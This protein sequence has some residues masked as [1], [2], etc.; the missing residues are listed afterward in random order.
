[1]KGDDDGRGEKVRLRLRRR[2]LF[3]SRYRDD[4][5]TTATS[6]EESSIR[7]TGRL[8]LQE[9]FGRR[10]TTMEA[11]FGP[12]PRRFSAKRYAPEKGEMVSDGQDRNKA[13]ELVA[14]HQE[15]RIQN[16]RLSA[17]GLEWK[18]IAGL[19]EPAARAGL[20]E[21][22]QSV[23]KN[24]GGIIDEAEGI[25]CAPA[26]ALGGEKKVRAQECVA[27]LRWG[28][29]D[30]VR[31]EELVRELSSSIDLLYDLSKT[32]KEMRRGTYPTGNG[33]SGPPPAGRYLDA[34]ASS[35]YN[36]SEET[37]V[38]PSR[39]NTS[40]TAVSLE[41]PPR[42]ELSNLDLPE[43]EPPAYVAENAQQPP[44]RVIGHL[45]Q[46]AKSWG[47][48]MADSWTVPV[49]VEY[50][51]FDPGYRKTGI[52][53][54]T[55]RLESLLSFYARCAPLPDF[56]AFATLPCLGFFEDPKHSRYGLV[57]ELPK[58]VQAVPYDERIEQRPA[59]LLQALQ[60]TMPQGS[61]SRVK[62][63]SPALEERFRLALNVV[64][65]FA[66]LHHEEQVHKD[67]NSTNIV[68]FNTRP[69]GGGG[70]ADAKTKYNL[71]APYVAS[72]DVFSEYSIEPLSAAPAQNLYR[73]PEDRRIYEAA[74]R[75]C[76]SRACK[77]PKYRF[78][79]YGLAVVLLEIGL[80]QPV[81][82]LYK[83]PYSLTEFKHRRLQNVYVR[84]LASRCG[85]VFMNVVLD[86]LDTSDTNVVGEVLADKY[87]RWL[88][89]LRRCCMLD[90]DEDLDVRSMIPSLGRTSPFTQLHSI[91]P[92]PA[93]AAPVL[94]ETHPFR[95]LSHRTSLP[96]SINEANEE[97]G[98][99]LEKTRDS[100]R[101]VDRKPSIATLRPRADADNSSTFSVSSS[102][103][104][105]ASV[106]ARAWRTKVC[107][108]T[109]R[110]CRAKVITLQ[111]CWRKR[112]SRTTSVATSQT[113]D[114]NASEAAA[115]DMPSL[116]ASFMQAEYMSTTTMTSDATH[117]LTHHNIA[118]HALITIA[119]PPRPRPKLRVFPIKLAKDALDT[120]HTTTLPRLERLLDRALRDSPETVSIDLLGVGDAPHSTR[121]T[122]FV[123]CDSVPRVRAVLARRFAA[124]PGFDL[125]IRRGCIRRSKVTRPKRCP[126]HRSMAPAADAPPLNPFHQQRPLCGASIGAW[127]GDRHLPPVSYGGV[128][129]VDGRAYGMT[130]HH[131]L[132]APSDDESDAG[133]EESY[134]SG[135]VQ[136]SA[137]RRPDNSWFAGLAGHPSLQALPPDGM[138]A[139][140]ISDDELEDATEEDWDGDF[141]Y[142]SYSDSESD[143]EE[144]G[145][146]ESTHTEGDAPG[147]V[148]HSHPPI[149]VT[150]PALDDVV[151]DFFPAAE[152]VDDDHLSSHTLGTV[153][154][155]SGIRRAQLG[156]VVH[157]IDWALLALAPERLQ[158]VNL[159][160]GGR[161]FHPAACGAGKG[162]GAAVQ[163]PVCRGAGFAAEED[164][165]PVRIAGADELG[166]LAVHCFGRTS[167]L[168]GGV[169]GE[170]M[171]SVRIYKRR[172]FARSWHVVGGF[173]VGGDSGAWV[174]DNAQ[175]R[176]VGHVL[177]W[178]ERNAL[179]Y[180][181]PMEVLLLDMKRA[182]GA[183]CVTLPGAER[184]DLVPDEIEDVRR[185]VEGIGLLEAPGRV[186]V[187]NGVDVFGPPRED[188]AQVGVQEV[189]GRGRGKVVRNGV[190][191]RMGFGGFVGRAAG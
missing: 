98:V 6:D 173:G 145:L 14:L 163:E 178:C 58:A 63:A 183:R 64:A 100:D 43:E 164:E 153:H 170:A 26:Q 95:P 56:D 54:P 2:A 119:T 80:W 138:F 112:A 114:D 72:F 49:L 182:L 133:S 99:L 165:Y 139:L 85:S 45:M 1:M 102:Y 125:K 116:N 19:E 57:Y 127:V 27:D 177:A 8:E 86:M 110:D 39:T 91:A 60:A 51:P 108:Q 28:A 174:I 97:G 38:T 76:G 146:R 69:G 33:K 185:A 15:F 36:T 179:A 144:E 53:V 48:G 143:N 148:P 21:T 62:A 83:P 61:S 156:G 166:G 130:V 142:A 50:A 122:I 73:H 180:I 155:S 172:S 5:A 137:A 190:P 120:W 89:R 126:P 135:G 31:Y 150:Q 157:E 111:R 129:H 161:R 105:A 70:G 96:Y 191:V 55:N 29:A 7:F 3:D 134:A 18:D 107:K 40:K 9:R 140:E 92:V 167:G 79:V 152:D 44:T 136:R 123:T 71:R 132:D 121:P 37:L 87:E 22:V 12:L 158:P 35:G 104:R 103:Q 181:C 65:A 113:F 162:V 23:L 52:P 24:I 42:I 84:K 168:Q 154:A 67:V 66:R 101:G 47:T 11:A 59:S 131:L 159:V 74:C 187:L 75:F 184:E 93:A 188:K 128:V 124:P 41:L 81:A 189:D 90:E 34:Y 109:Y 115:R 4:T 151:P 77:C 169:V 118:H 30:R 46:P 106:I 78:D 94:A 117:H 16:E 17:W 160:Q 13:P 20:H 176:V 10:N 141:G 186:E 32:K 147:V 171:S 175:G 68:F 149:P 88:H 25:R 82:E